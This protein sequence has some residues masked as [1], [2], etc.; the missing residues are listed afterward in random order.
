MKLL[1]TR[2]IAIMVSNH[3]NNAN[4]PAKHKNNANEDAKQENDV[5]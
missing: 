4:E 5:K 3:K 1:S 2:T